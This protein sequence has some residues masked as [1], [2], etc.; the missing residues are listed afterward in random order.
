[1][2]CFVLYLQPSMVW[3]HAMYV[4]PYLP[5]SPLFCPSKLTY[6]VSLAGPHLPPSV[7]TLMASVSPL[8]SML[9]TPVSSVISP[10][11]MLYTVPF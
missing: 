8:Y 6:S 10:Y 5:V 4:H 1:M 7:F 3:V 11:C 2:K 9:L